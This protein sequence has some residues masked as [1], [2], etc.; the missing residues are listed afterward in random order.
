VHG[1]TYQLLFLTPVLRLLSIFMEVTRDKVGV[2]NHFSLTKVYVDI[3][4][5]M[6]RYDLGLPRRP[7]K[8]TSDGR[9]GERNKISSVLT[10]TSYIFAHCFQTELYDYVEK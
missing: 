4:H 9:P 2:C 8:V 6:L 7:R 10:G 5:A 3:F 1:K